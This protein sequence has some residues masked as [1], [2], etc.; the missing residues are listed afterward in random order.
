MEL[1]QDISDGSNRHKP[2]V[3]LLVKYTT[4]K[5]HKSLIGPQV[6][7]AHFDQGCFLQQKLLF[8]AKHRNRLLWALSIGQSG[9]HSSIKR[10]VRGS[11]ITAKR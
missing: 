5:V 9:V 7:R 6:T 8:T 11:N 3:I 1:E 4:R 2:L 10:V